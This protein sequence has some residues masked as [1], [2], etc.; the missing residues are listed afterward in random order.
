MEL[1]YIKFY[2]RDW[3]GDQQLGMCSL[4]AR[5]LWTD[6]LCIMASSG[7][8]GYLEVGGVPIKDATTLARQVRAG[9][10]EVAKA[11]SELQTIGVFSRD[12]TGVIFSRRMVHDATVSEMKRQA[13][14][15]GGNPAL[16]KQ[17][18]PRVVKRVN[19]VLLKQ[20]VKPVLKPRDHKPETRDQRSKTISHEP[21][22]NSLR[23]QGSGLSKASFLEG[24]E[25]ESEQDF[26]ALLTDL[27]GSD[28]GEQW[29]GRWRK[30]WRQHQ[31][32]CCRALND[33]RQAVKEGKG[34][35]SFGGYLNDVFDKR[36]A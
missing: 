2:P 33:L 21:L 29:N 4:A 14:L 35:E 23:V 11:L 9:A 13:G 27:C 15:Q 3:T 24:A 28:E 36:M 17:P 22:V 12:S 34:I 16:I 25:P 8:R 18:A 32:K 19:K 26:I 7:R 1:P 30:R 5:G 20:V 10:D 6:M 31:S